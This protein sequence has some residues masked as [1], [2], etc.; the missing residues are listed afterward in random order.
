[1]VVALWLGKKK[2]PCIL[3]TLAEIVG[4]KSYDGRSLTFKYYPHLPKEVVK[5][6]MGHS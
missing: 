4:M 5:G 2:C 1:M 6:A 3:E